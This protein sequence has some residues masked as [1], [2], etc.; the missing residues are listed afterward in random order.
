MAVNKGK[1]GGSGKEQRRF[2]RRIAGERRTAVRWEPKKNDRRKNL[3]R[4]GNDGT[5]YP[6]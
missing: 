3:G 6:D 1:G 2:S 5:R 4:R